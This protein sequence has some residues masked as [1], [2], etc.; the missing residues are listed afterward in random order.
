MA[1]L[2]RRPDIVDIAELREAEQY[3]T[4]SEQHLLGEARTRIT[5]RLADTVLADLPV[6]ADAPAGVDQW[7]LRTDIGRGLPDG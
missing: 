1:R 2:V 3:L 5:Y 6:P 7:S 4:G